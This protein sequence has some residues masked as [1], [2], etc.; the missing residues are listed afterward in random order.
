[1]VWLPLGFR[2]GSL[3]RRSLFIHN[4][5]II[6]FY[7]LVMET[8]VR[9]RR[10]TMIEKRQRSTETV[11]AV[12]PA[13]QLL[14][15]TITAKVPTVIGNN[16]DGSLESRFTS[17]DC[18][19]RPQ[20]STCISGKAKFCLKA[21]TRNLSKCLDPL[22]NIGFFDATTPCQTIVCLNA[23]TPTKHDFCFNASTPYQ[24]YS[25]D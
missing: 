11:A 7:L 15:A 20:L 4:V 2:I 18:N 10:I 12:V 17:G 6:K 19:P 16:N 23:T 8:V 1:M 9:L 21:S 5:G 24:T 13:S 3:S 25:F 14:L 22:P